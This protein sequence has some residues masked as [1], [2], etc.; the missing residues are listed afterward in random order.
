MNEIFPGQSHNYMSFG[1]LTP[2]I[3]IKTFLTTSTA[4]L[5]R[6]EA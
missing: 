1:N 3:D 4:E 5:I 2:F 6:S